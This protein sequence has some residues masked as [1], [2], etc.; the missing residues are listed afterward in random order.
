MSLCDG[1]IAEYHEL[2]KSSVE[3]FLIKLDNAVQKIL[4]QQP[5][6]EIIQEEM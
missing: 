1:G 2:M 6:E 4:R 3:D 5:Q